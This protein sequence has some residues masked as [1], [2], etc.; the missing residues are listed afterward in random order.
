MR[1]HQVL[2]EAHVR[3]FLD[4]L[5]RHK[6]GHLTAEEAGERLGLSGRHIRRYRLRGGGG[7][8]NRTTGFLSHEADKRCNR[9]SRAVLDPRAARRTSH[10]AIRPLHREETGGGL[11]GR[12]PPGPHKQSAQRD[13]A[14]TIGMSLTRV[15]GQFRIF[16]K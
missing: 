1:R 6:Q 12:T 9:K 2:W 15:A 4:A 11:P 14:T 7:C 5:D 8:Q 16:R 3:R 10:G 13:R